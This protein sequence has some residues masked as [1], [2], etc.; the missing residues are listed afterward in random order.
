MKYILDLSAVVA[1]SAAAVCCHSQNGPPAETHLETRYALEVIDDATFYGGVPQSYP[2]TLNRVLLEPSFGF[3]VDRRFTFSSSLIGV[4]TTQSDTA[5]QGLVREAYAG[6]SAGEFDFTAG[7]KMVRWGTGYAFTAAGV[8]DPPRVPTD[9]SDRLNLNEGRDMVKTD[10]VHGPHALS[11]AWSTAA[12]ARSGTPM[13]D[14]SALRYNVLVHGF[15]TALIAGKDRGS[16]AF[17]ALTFTRVVGQAWE[18]HGEATWR[19]HEAILLGAK[20]T[21]KNGVTLIGEFFT[22]PNI[23]YYRSSGISPLAG[24]QHY[25]FLNAGKT[26]LRELPGWKEWD[27]SGSIVANLDDS[28]CAGVVDVS[29][30][31]GKHVSSYVHVEVPV[32]GKVSQYGAAPYTEATSVGVR[33]QL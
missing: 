29:R 30:W 26:R 10:W 12:L 23:P 15:D 20:Y 1:L 14:T 33:F 4:T 13:H 22:P 24:R 27:V 7:R 16:D 17:G 19:E 32:G 8:L 18:L 21:M 9:P 11:F 6:L 5:S 28:S 2:H 3:K 25:A 31:F